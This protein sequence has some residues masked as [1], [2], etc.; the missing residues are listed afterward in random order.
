[1]FHTSVQIYLEFNS[2]QRVD[3]NLEFKNDFLVQRVHTLETEMI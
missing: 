3:E 2:R 1:M